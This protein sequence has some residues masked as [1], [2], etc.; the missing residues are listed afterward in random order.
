MI[1]YLQ[2]EILE[3]DDG[4]ILVGIGDS[5]SL[6]RVGYLVSVPGSANYGAYT[7]GQSVQLFVYTHVR[8]EALDL[9]G[10]TTQQ[11]KALF[12]TL[13]GVNGIGPKSALG[14]LS[15]VEP[16]DLIDAIVQEDQALLTR[17]PGIGKKTA[18][19]VVVELKDTVRKKLEAGVFSKRTRDDGNRGKV[20]RSEKLESASA[21]E[22]AKAAL[23]GLG[24]RESDIHQLL[25]RVLDT[26][27][28]RPLKTEDLIR[29][30][31]RQLA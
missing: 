6:G 14:I 9:Y 5:K 1:G 29:S 10:F 24:Y 19:R 22:D 26:T 3:Q 20:G 2:G 4:K 23:V 31:L 30:A 7:V 13:L 27:E 25:N 17:I 8:E 18:E 16:L 12:L 11:E 21:F 15:R 28:P